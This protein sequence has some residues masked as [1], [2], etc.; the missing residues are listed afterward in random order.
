MIISERYRF[1]FVHIPKCAGTSVRQALAVFDETGGEFSER[2]ADD[3]EFGPLDY[4]HLPL[5]L[6][7][8]VAP[9][10]YAKL[11]AY[12]AYAIARNPFERFPSAMAQRMKMYRGKEMAQAEGSELRAE[13][14][15]ITA[16][17]RDRRHVT[18]PA[19]I[20]FARQTDFVWDGAER[21]VEQVFPVERIGLFMA[22]MEQRIGTPLGT[23]QH[24][25]R[26][27]IFRFNQLRSAI[28]LGSAAAKRWLPEP[29]SRDL[30]ERAR[31][32]LMRPAAKDALPEIFRSQAVSEFVADYYAGDLALHLE[33]LSRGDGAAEPAPER[34]AS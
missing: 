26:A 20:H 23:A 24:E 4:T 16:Y 15:D 21:L 10:A 2:V 6:L 18:D 34:I 25:N 12:D 27:M 7:R 14:E 19:Y 9:Q 11:A 28:M 22:A 13:L 1:V 32:L 5:H 3:P 30:R 17:L 8:R 31:G 29:L 33:A